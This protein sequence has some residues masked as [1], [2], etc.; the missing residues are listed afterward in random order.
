[1]HHII[2]M[3]N[4]LL[5][6]LL[7][8]HFS[9]FS[10]NA[11]SFCIEP[12]I[13]IGGTEM[14][15]RTTDELDG[16]FN[17]SKTSLN[18]GALLV[19]RRRKDFEWGVGVKYS[20]EGGKREMYLQNYA[21]KMREDIGL[22]YLRI[23]IR[24]TFLSN[25]V[26]KIVGRF[27]LGPSFGML[28]GGKTRIVYDRLADINTNEPPPVMQESK[29]YWKKFDVSAT[30]SVGVTYE[31]STN[32]SLVAEGTLLRGLTDNRKEDKKNMVGY[33]AGRS[34]KSMTYTF[35]AGVNYR[36]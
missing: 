36:L 29:D 11:Q 25:Q 31:I 27:S 4:K 9:C 10:I 20:S 8:L 14:S 26:R 24:A 7:I 18:V 6:P 2:K 17:M 35:N 28:M 12:S 13:G 21:L 32:V 3:M 5:L 19:Y 23:P 34:F 15:H 1:M 22:T 33:P 30:A 16:S